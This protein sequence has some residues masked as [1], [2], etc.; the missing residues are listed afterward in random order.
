MCFNVFDAVFWFNAGFALMKEF[1]AL[2]DNWEIFVSMFFV[3]L[4]WSHEKRICRQVLR[5][6]KN[7]LGRQVTAYCSCQGSS[8]DPF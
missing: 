2:Y 8:A 7:V 6:F 1:V 5:Y 4:T 3:R